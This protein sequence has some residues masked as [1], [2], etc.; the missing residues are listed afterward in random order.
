MCFVCGPGIWSDIPVT[1]EVQ[2]SFMSEL[3]LA[4]SG[5]VTRFVNIVLIVLFGFHVAEG[6]FD[7]E[8][9]VSS[10]APAFVILC[11]AGSIDSAL[12]LSGIK[13][14]PAIQRERPVTQ[15]LAQCQVNTPSALTASLSCQRFG[16]ISSCAL[17][18]K[19]PGEFYRSHYACIPGKRI[20]CLAE[21]GKLFAFCI[22]CS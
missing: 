1:I 7:G 4:I 16:R 19:T 8:A 11:I 21:E 10:A 14:I 9:Y 22:I 18:R 15:I 17:K 20:A 12:E 3:S 6:I 2:T 13:H 5:I